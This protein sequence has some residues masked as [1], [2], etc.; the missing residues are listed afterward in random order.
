[1]EN[2]QQGIANG[3]KAGYNE[4]SSPRR[5]AGVSLPTGEYS[6]ILV[7]DIGNTT[8]S[9]GG[10]EISDRNEYRVD[11]TTK[12]DTNCT[13]DTADYTI[14]LLKKLRFLGKET[15]EFSGIVISSVVPRVLDVVRE[16]LNS[17]FGLEPLVVTCESRLGLTLDVPEPQKL[18]RDRLAD[19]AWAAA[20]YPLPVVTADLGTATTFNVI[21]AGGV[22]CGGV[23]AAGM[24]T[25]LKALGIHTAQLPKLELQ[26]PEQVIG[27]NTEACMLSG[28]VIGT[29]ALLDGIVTA[30]EQELGETVS[31]V[32][33]GGGA[34]YVD[35]LVRHPHSYDPNMILK[36]L[37]YLYQLNK[38]E[39]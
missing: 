31:F 30:I 23:I 38:A 20:N 17:I 13:W 14:R 10:I 8:V 1:M 6:M 18:G 19:S 9:F 29:A 7:V 28:A 2:L 21:K 3:K 37:A 27:K 39:N 36:G 24:E 5:F 25:G 16:A 4:S 35:K 11:F 15:A 33:T 34:A 22:F 26:A 12:L 32:I